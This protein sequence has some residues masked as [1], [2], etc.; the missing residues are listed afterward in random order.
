MTAGDRPTIITPEGVPIDLKIAGPATRIIARLVDLLVIFGVYMTLAGF[1]ASGFEQADGDSLLIIILVVGFFLAMF[2]YPVVL[3]TLWQG[4]TV[5]KAVVGTRVIADDGG[6]IGFRHAAVRSILALIDVWLSLGGVAV[7]SVFVSSRYQRLGDMAAGTLVVR[8]PDDLDSKPVRFVA[9]RNLAAFAES[10]PAHR[11]S[12]D[13]YLL[14]RD[15][16]LNVV[17]LEPEAR[18]AISNDLAAKIERRLDVARPPAIRVDDYLICVAARYQASGSGSG[19][20]GMA[21]S[22]P[23]E[24]D[25]V[26]ASAAVELPDPFVA[27]APAPPT[28]PPPVA[29]SADPLSQ[30]AQAGDDD[31]PGFA[32]P[33]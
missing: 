20:S 19:P 12:N 10:L 30:Q 18:Q 29:S 14:L 31:D 26:A 22:T 6:P 7:V 21:R 33:G 32:V 2:A 4:R 24:V 9:P 13:D 16:I 25:R 17:S 5:G 8:L 28:V 15:T 27:S 3:E 23:S 1:A 11:L